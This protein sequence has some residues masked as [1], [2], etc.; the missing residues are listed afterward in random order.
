MGARAPPAA[1]VAQRRPIAR[2]PFPRGR[3][4]V[5]RLKAH[6]FSRTF[7]EAASKISANISFTVK[8]SLTWGERAALTADRKE[9]SLRA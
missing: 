9:P 7:G 2:E 4:S 5:V 3:S 6:F 8:R 1:M